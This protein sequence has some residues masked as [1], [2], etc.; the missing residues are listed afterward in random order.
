VALP[1]AGVPLIEELLRDAI[2]V[3]EQP[4]Y[5]AASWRARVIADLEIDRPW[6]ARM[7]DAWLRTVAERGCTMVNRD[8]IAARSIDL[9]PRTAPGAQGHSWSQSYV[10]PA[11]A[12]RQGPTP[13]CTAADLPRPR[14][15]AR[16]RFS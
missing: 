10:D 13:T 9:D 11:W 8:V 5:A 3:Y 2:V 15:C 16:R 12:R 1:D 7:R 14:E 4:A 6:Y